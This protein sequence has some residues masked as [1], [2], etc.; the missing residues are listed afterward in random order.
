MASFSTIVSTKCLLV[1]VDDPFKGS[2]D[3][4]VHEIVDAHSKPAMYQELFTREPQI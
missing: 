3:V 2:V 4:V 1:N